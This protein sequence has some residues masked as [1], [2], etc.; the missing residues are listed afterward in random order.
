MEV[1]EQTANVKAIK[2]T[3]KEAGGNSQKEDTKMQT[4]KAKWKMLRKR[5]I[6]KINNNVKVQSKNELIQNKIF[7]KDVCNRKRSIIK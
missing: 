1:R 5:V 3:N 7:K 4:Q 6:K 2:R